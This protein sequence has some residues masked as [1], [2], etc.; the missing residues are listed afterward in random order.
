MKKW[1]ILTLVMMVMAAWAVTSCSEEDNEVE[2]YPDW[3]A[4]NDNFFNHLSDSV[5][6]LLA[7]DPSR[8]DW[9]RIKTWSKSEAVEGSNSDYIIVHVISEDDPEATDCPKYTDTA[10][11]S[12]IGRLL[13]STSYPNGFVFD[14]TFDGVYDKE[15]S[16]STSFTIGNDTG[17]SLVDGFATAL[18]H[19]HRG[20]RWMVY[21]PYQLGYGSTENGTIPAYST[22]IF[23]LILIDFWSPGYGE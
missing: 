17:N 15:V 3:Q 16:A 11:V 5:K 23:D 6:A 22:L 7:A 10:S 4:T 2:E 14:Q 1:K 12:Y 20:D 21:I 9:K 8:T 18:Q 13:P 19:M